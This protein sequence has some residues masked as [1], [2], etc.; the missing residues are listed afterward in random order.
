[1][2]KVPLYYSFNFTGRA[3]VLITEKQTHN[4]WHKEAI[5]CSQLRRHKPRHNKDC[6]ITLLLPLH[7]II[8]YLLVV[9]T[10]LMQ[11]IAKALAL[12]TA[13][14]V[15]KLTLRYL[16][17]SSSS[18]LGIRPISSSHSTSLSLGHTTLSCPG[19]LP[20]DRLTHRVNSSLDWLFKLSTICN[21]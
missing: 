7:F 12:T 13:L 2:I 8:R 14:V 10:L 9:S 17:G 11:Y 6:A 19:P 3:D 15:S 4:A 16:P 18:S 21:L 5:V 20:T 1:M